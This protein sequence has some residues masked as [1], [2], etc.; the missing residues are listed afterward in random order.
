MER[1]SLNGIVSEVFGGGGG[2]KLETYV[3]AR[4]KGSSGFKEDIMIGLE[5]W[6][7][8]EGCLGG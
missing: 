2:N 6:R 5:T 4:R 7:L 3:W 8:I 1:T